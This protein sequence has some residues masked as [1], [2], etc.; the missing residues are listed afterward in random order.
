MLADPYGPASLVD[1][2]V[3]ALT[4]LTTRGFSRQQA[5]EVVI[6]A[7][8]AVAILDAKDIISSAKHLGYNTELLTMPEGEA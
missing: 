6:H 2:E 4:F 1:T 8:V 3:H 7:L 5:F